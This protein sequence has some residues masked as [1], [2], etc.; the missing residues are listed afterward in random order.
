MEGL[1]SALLKSPAC[2]VL[3]SVMCVLVR[4]NKA[5]NSEGK[6][7]FPGKVLYC[8]LVIGGDVIFI[9]ILAVH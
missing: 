3:R 6:K 1:L 8:G 7:E 5:C 2:R 9:Y 4:T